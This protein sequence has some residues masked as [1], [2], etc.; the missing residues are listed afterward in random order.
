[1]KY[2]H[3]K[4]YQKK[5]GELDASGALLFVLPFPLIL[6]VLLNL[7][8]GQFGNLVLAG[9]MLT[10][11]M[12][13]AW[14]LRAGLKAQKNYDK[15]IIALA[16]KYR[17]KTS[18]AIIYS[19]TTFLLVWQEIGHSL[20]IALCIGLLSWLGC[21]WA[22]GSDPRK[23]KSIGANTHGYTTAEVIE[24]LEEGEDLVAGIERASNSISN[25][26]MSDRLVRITGL[27]RNILTGLAADPRDLRRA[28]KFLKTYLE[29]ANKVIQGYAQ[30]HSN[31]EQSALS[32]RF[33]NV[34]D[35]IE[36]V[37]HE[38]QTVLSENDLFDLDVK[39]EVLKTQLEREGVV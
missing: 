3:P 28:R 27:A 23:E 4:R 22:Y 25:P 15:K 6:V 33:I 31:G 21:Y 39:M 9:L 10:L 35:T 18:G 37:F 1:M 16:P 24:A 29:G 2:Q 13:G 30:T 34:L 5:P 14:F 11:F 36:T 38:Q 7:W 12:L 20:L 32:A 8:R 19:G 17:N 26:Q